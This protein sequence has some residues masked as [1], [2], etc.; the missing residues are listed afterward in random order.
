VRGVAYFI[1]SAPDTDKGLNDLIACVTSFNP[2]EQNP[3][4]VSKRSPR[5]IKECSKR[6]LNNGEG[7]LCEWFVNRRTQSLS[8]RL[9]NGILH[10]PYMLR[11]QH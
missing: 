3:W 9:L 4:E 7:P 6:N 8:F 2:E 5:T 1:M 10:Y 11:P